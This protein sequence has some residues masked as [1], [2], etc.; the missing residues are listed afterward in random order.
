[1]QAEVEVT[2]RVPR[3]QVRHLR[4]AR[5][6]ADG[7]R[8]TVVAQ[9]DGLDHA[10]HAL[11]AYGPDVEVLEPPELRARVARAV[12]DAAALYAGVS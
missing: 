12:N 10:F 11:L 3:S 9:F 2:V 6:V 5:M 7:E 4:G 8:P 1:V